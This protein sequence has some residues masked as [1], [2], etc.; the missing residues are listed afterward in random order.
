MPTRDVFALDRSGFNGFLY[1]DIGTEPGG[2]R[3]TV[4]SALA[5]LGE[6]PWA[7]AAL[8]ARM[9]KAA[10]SAALAAIIAQMPVA[11]EDRR[12]AAHTATRL[13]Q[14]L[15]PPPPA[16]PRQPGFA[17][18]LPRRR[19]ALVVAAAACLALL[20]GGAILVSR[21]GPGAQA[22]PARPVASKVI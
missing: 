11:P 18:L 10:A 12:A 17:R 22:P 4:L 1:A 6:D 2:S 16:A 7:Q 21:A 8:W 5:R 9:P 20:L 15:A 13:V 19:L 14:L 3:L